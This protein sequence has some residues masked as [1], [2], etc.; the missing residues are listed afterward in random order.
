VSA[1]EGRPLDGPSGADVPDADVDVRDGTA[2]ASRFPTPLSEG[3][4]D[5]D[6]M[7]LADLISISARYAGNLSFDPDSTA[8]GT[9]ADL[10]TADPLFVLAEVSSLSLTRNGAVLRSMSEARDET[11]LALYVQDVARTLDLL[12]RVLSSSDDP[13]LEAFRMD[14]EHLIRE[15][16]AD[17]RRAV[18]F[19]DSSP[20]ER[21]RPRRYAW[22]PLWSEALPA[23]PEAAG[24]A[25][26]DLARFD[27]TSHRFLQ[28]IAHL[29]E[30]GAGLLE[31]VLH[32][33]RR[34]P[35]LGLAL[36]FLELFGE[37]QRKL[38][39]FSRRRLEFYF[40]DVLGFKPRARVS[41]QAHIALSL[42]PGVR[43]VLVPEG[44]GFSA[45]RD[46]RKNDLVY[47]STSDML[48]TD[49]RVE[50]IV[51]LHFE[52]D[53]LVS[54]E[55]ELDFV[56]GVR[57]ERVP[58]ER[59]DLSGTGNSPLLRAVRGEGVPITGDEASLG[60]AVASPVL[61][62][63]E[64]RR[65]ISF[66]IALAVP[67]R[68]PSREVQLDRL[69]RSTDPAEFF[70]RFGGLFAHELMT[71]PSWRSG[72]TDD[73]RKICEKARSLLAGPRS[74]DSIEVIE[75]LLDRDRRAL[76]HD[77]FRHGFTVLCSAPDGW[78]EVPEHDVAPLEEG[79]GLEITIELGPEAPPIVPFDGA[80]HDG[81]YETD[82]PMVG[83]RVSSGSMFH[84]YSLLRAFD[85]REIGIEVGVTGATDLHA[86]NQLGAVDPTKPFQPF[87]P[88]PSRDS[89]L[90]VGNYE[91]ARKRLK[92]ASLDI[93]WAEVPRDAGGWR[94]YYAG[95][96]EEV[97]GSTLKAE[98]SVLHDS[99][100]QPADPG[101]RREARL[102]D[103]VGR[104]DRIASRRTLSLDVM[105]YFQPLAPAISEEEFRTYR[106]PRDGLFRLSLRASE[107]GFGHLEYPQL[108]T[109]TFL[110][111]AASKRKEREPIPNA[112]YTPQIS[113]LSLDYVAESVVRIGSA[114]AG[115]GGRTTER[116]FHEHPFGSLDL[117][118]A[119]F[120]RAFS[121]VPGGPARV[122]GRRRT[123]R[124]G[125]LLVGF[126]STRPAG[127]LALL[128]HMVRDASL[129]S[130]ALTSQVD[131][132]YLA[133]NRWH[134]LEPDRIVND[135][136]KGLLWSGIVTLDLP[137]DID[138]RN[139]VL[140]ND[141]FWIAAGVDDLESVAGRL[142]SITAGGMEVVWEDRGN[143][144]PAETTELP[145]G[146]IRAPASPL[147]GVEGVKQIGHSFGGQPAEDYERLVTRASERLR[148]KSRTCTPWDYEH[149]VLEH[150]PY[151]YKVKC[152]P[153]LDVDRFPEP[154]PGSVLIVV[155]PR[156]MEPASDEAPMALIG[157]T[158][159]GRIGD[160]L[161][162][163]APPAARITV[164]NPAYEQVQVRCR[165]KLV[166]GEGTG[167][168]LQRLNQALIDFIAPWKTDGRGGRFGWSI[169]QKD[170]AGHIHD[171]PFVDFVTDLS[172]LHITQDKDR[173]HVPDRFRLR[174]TARVFE[175]GS[176]KTEPDL[177][178]RGEPLPE[179]EVSGRYPW[180]LAIPS[181]RHFI[182]T[183]AEVDQIAARITGI[184]ELEIGRNFIVEAPR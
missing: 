33:K 142:H 35:A 112:P 184:G 102:F 36:T 87:G 25:D 48:V 177:D 34:P 126:S 5:V 61:H 69:L 1:D 22:H 165:V 15:L 117:G 114:R 136:T 84:P 90:V 171:L 41:D 11:G 17:R 106:R 100:W 120:D 49:A 164:R 127:P 135:T 70:T 99:Q 161:R 141:Q 40:L 124:D 118:D 151:L 143:V 68:S 82:L 145:A 156:L 110:A 174:D 173:L 2:Q 159:L 147:P 83:F 134:A 27:A 132:Y 71:R 52:K 128:V 51:T 16:A 13:R 140:P 95:Y 39:E 179:N 109:R 116:I 103:T 6:E 137:T 85:L 10:F 172:L 111:N 94:Q 121:L 60:F 148:H 23:S 54:P 154:S 46:E 55:R 129:R 139:T 89:F 30:R 20:D 113:S 63:R 101:R 31:Q 162:R 45:G 119:S 79:V 76:F 122:R 67:E 65:R 152:F 149:L 32:T 160:V 53:Q 91:A 158:E 64:G 166:K 42:A 3:Y 98:I 144:R 37:A 56:T 150:F 157:G 80:V 175:D 183:V 125:Y 153:H 12:Y 14:F 9:W 57:A 75:D 168:S 78:L 72:M 138:R 92:Q 169:R 58:V 47:V 107:T 130:T 182:Q 131:W 180:S 4:F 74:S 59:F 86:Y 7:R 104:G 73:R 108:L 18:A 28:A 167:P 43:E 97:S 146:T 155:V 8:A 170:V 62:L 19:L 88:I 96:D 115:E 77:L 176:E 29:K 133:S 21:D 181:R 123:E 66:R 163:I 26:A 44:T 93:E 50:S 38:N 105:E 81:S 24:Q 178:D